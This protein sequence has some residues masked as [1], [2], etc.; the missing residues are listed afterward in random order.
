MMTALFSKRKT[1]LFLDLIPW[2]KT[3]ESFQIHSQLHRSFPGR[4]PRS[5]LRSAW[6]AADRSASERPFLWQPGWYVQ[7]VQWA[8]AGSALCSPKITASH[9]TRSEQEPEECE[10][11]WKQPSSILD[12]MES[13]ETGLTANEAPTGLRIHL[14]GFFRGLTVAGGAGVCG[15]CSGGKVCPV[16]KG[17][18]FPNE[19]LICDTHPES[20]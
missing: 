15:S 3:K 2:G 20:S 18:K 7:R 8:A 9:R 17:S 13:K 14:G 19:L 1:N 10:C 11:W 4:N 12:I 5:C 6:P 16:P